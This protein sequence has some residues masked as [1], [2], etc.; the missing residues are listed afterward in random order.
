MTEATLQARLATTLETAIEASSIVVND[1]NTPQVSPQHREP[2]AIIETADMVRLNKG[3]S[4]SEPSIIYEP[5][6]GLLCYRRGR[7]EAETLNHFQATRQA[8]FAALADDGEVREAETET[9]IG[10]FFREDGE[11]DPDSLF[12]RIRLRMEEFEVTE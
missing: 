4:F 9:P 11:P 6:I 10:P 12:Q 2:W 3:M 7:T 8:V 1:Y 5:F